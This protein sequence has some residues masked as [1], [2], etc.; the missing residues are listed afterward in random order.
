MTINNSLEHS[1][2]FFLTTF[3]I[4]RRAKDYPIMAENDW[5]L[6]LGD[7][8]WVITNQLEKDGFVKRSSLAQHID[9]KFTLDELKNLAS[10]NGLSGLGRK[11]EVILRLITS[12]S[13]KMWEIASEENIFECSEKGLES[14]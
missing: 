13:S 2:L 9:R 5:E 3:L 8:P 11:E 14:V 12:D 1:K 6:L 4:P 10:Q 7:N